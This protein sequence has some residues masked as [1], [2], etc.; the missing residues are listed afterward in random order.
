M[1]E[2]FDMAEDRFSNE[3]TLAK[4]EGIYDHE[5][6]F[7]N[8]LFM[9]SN[10]FVT[11]PYRRKTTS[12]TTNYPKPETLKIA[13]LSFKMPNPESHITEATTKAGEADMALKLN[14][15]IYRYV[16]FD[17]TGNELSQ[18]EILDIIEQTLIKHNKVEDPLH[19]LLLN[20]LA[21]SYKDSDLLNGIKNIFNR[22]KNK[23]AIAIL[24]TYHCSRSFFNVSQLIYPEVMNGKVEHLDASP[25][26]KQSSAIRQNEM[27]RT[28]DGTKFV[29]YNT[30]YGI[31]SVLICLDMYDPNLVFKLMRTNHRLSYDHRT[32]ETTD[33]TVKNE[34]SNFPQPESSDST[35]V[36][37][38]K[39]ELANPVDIV[40]IPS[41]NAD[42]EINVDKLVRSISK[43]GRSTLLLCND[44]TN[45]RSAERQ[46][47]ANICYRFGD[48]VPMDAEAMDEK[49]NLSIYRLDNWQNRKD[50]LNEPDDW[51]P[52]FA[53]I[54]G[55]QSS[56]WKR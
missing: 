38:D 53:K 19:F 21:L 10:R 46:W 11:R 40:F 54:I 23:T 17:V 24:G 36:K 44:S 28:T 7:L 26:A 13:A 31:I 3:P 48:K 34:S 25:V 4:K 12:S 6:E 15:S 27:I 52:I 1:E 9:N 18:Q 49:S 22:L 16:E 29:T 5:I 42:E 37:T 20:E 55:I 39:A 8:N 45:L 43:Y 33:G 14:G 56:H 2:H 30:P 41:Y 50:R 51:S 47:N 32:Q 35:E